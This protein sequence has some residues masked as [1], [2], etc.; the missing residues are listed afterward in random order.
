VTG[1]F[2]VGT[3]GFAYKEWKGD[4]YPPDIRSEDM[5]RFYSGRFPSVEIN[6]TFQRHPTEHTLARWIADTPDGFVFS[7][8]MHRQVTHI[9]RLGGEVAEPLAQFMASIA[10]LGERLGL[11]LV[12]CPPTLKADL[13]RFKAFMDLLPADRRFAFEFRH[14]S[15]HTDEVKAELAERGVAWCVADADDLDAPLERTAPGFVSLRLRKTVYEDEALARWAKDIAEALADGTDV[16]CYFK[17]EDEGR[18]VHFA[19]KLNELVAGLIAPPEDSGQ[20]P[21]E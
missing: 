15:C 8:K 6:Y 18:G 16:Y 2:Y 17:H 14:E 21:S 9:R 7:P 13:D 5:L 12:Q 4:F 1:R 19:G 3:S 11:V 10:P 20:A